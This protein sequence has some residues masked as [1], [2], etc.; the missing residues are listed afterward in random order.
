[1]YRITSLYPQYQYSNDR[2]QQNIPVE[3]DRRSGTDR[4]AQDRVKLDEKLTRDIF[5]VKGKIKDIT[6]TISFDSS[7]NNVKNLANINAISSVQS[8]E[9]V[10]TK[11]QSEQTARAN[12]TSD[13]PSRPLEAGLLA[14]ALAGVLFTPFIGP[15]GAVIALGSTVYV[16]AKLL[17]SA[18][19]EQTKDT[20][21][22]ENT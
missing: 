3:F 10:K 4:R 11:N 6:G 15:I 9:F 14:V 18:I 1:M 17:K 7:Q 13:S 16:G 22:K 2:R 20:N 19:V 12:T 21:K 5:E 8:D